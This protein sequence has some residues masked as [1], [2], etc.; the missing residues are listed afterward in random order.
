MSRNYKFRNPEGAYFISFAVVE[1]VDVFAY[2]PYKDIVVD[3]L[4]YCQKVKGLE[5]FAWC[6]MSN[7]VHLMIRAGGKSTLSDIL[8][9][10]KAFT[11]RQLLKVISEKPN[12]IN[13][14]RMLDTFAKAG[15][16]SSNVKNYQLWQHD[17]QPIE[18]YSNHVIQQ[19]LNYIHQNPVKAGFVRN[20]WDY[21]YSSAKN[22]A[23]EKGELEIILVG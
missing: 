18:V 3:S 4:R 19:K 6:I 8:R 11:A 22:Y 23:G 14:Q 13:S 5:I 16:K 12:E 9:D 20:P 15:A 7:H 17:N 2:D 1:W 10:F 21:K